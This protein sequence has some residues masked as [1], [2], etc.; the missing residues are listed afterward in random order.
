METK[1][2]TAPTTATPDEL[3]TILAP[4]AA[5]LASNQ[6]VAFPTE[7]VYGLGGNA[8]SDEAVQKIFAA[9]GRPGDNP[10]IVHVCDRHMIHMVAD[11][12]TPSAEKL[13]DKFLPGPLTDLVP[14]NDKVSKYCTAGERVL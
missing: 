1:T 6:V 7:T 11:G 4:A 14:C 3:R 8:M 9:K 13:V 10:L 12:L 5:L 2:W